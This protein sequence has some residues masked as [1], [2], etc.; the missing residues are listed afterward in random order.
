[1]KKRLYY[2]VLFTA[3][4]MLPDAASAQFA[5]KWM[6]VGSLHD[7]YSEIGCEIEEG[8]LKVQQYGLRWPAIYEF[9]DSKAA[10]AMWIGAKDFTDEN[11]NAF[12]HKVV[13]VGPRVSGD[14]EFFPI[15][16]RMTSQ[17]S[18]PEVAVDALQSFDLPVD[19][20]DV[21]EAL[22][23][24]RMIV[25]VTNSQ[26][27]VTMERKIFQFGQQYHDN[28]IVYDYTFTNTGNTDADDDIELP[29]QTLEGVYFFFHY[30]WS[31]ARQT[32]YVIGNATGWGINSMLDTRGDGVKEDPSDEQFRAQ[33]T[34]HGH[35]P[36]FT[37][38]DNLGAPIWAPDGPGFVADADTIGRLGSPQFVG[39]VTLHA[40]K[41]AAEQVDDPSQ[42]ATT[43]WESSD[44][45]LTSGNS[46]FD[47]VKMTREYE[48]M[49]A[50]HKSPRHVDVVEPSGNFA[51]PT[52]DPALGTPGGFSN[53]N[54]YGPYTLEP[55]QSIRIVLAEAVSGISREVATDIGV[56]YKNGEITAREKNEWVLSGQDSLFQTF[57]R[58]IANFESDW[59]I[60]RPPKPPQFFNIDGKGDR[61]SLSWETYDDNDSNLAGFRIY[62][63]RSEVDS[64]YTLIHEAGPAERSFEDRTP[65]RGVDYY[66]YI[67]SVGKAEDN[68]GAGMTPGGAL[69]SSRYYTQS[70]DPVNLKRPAVNDM[71]SIRVV[72]NPFVISA[73]NEV[74][75]SGNQRDELKFFN[76]PG[77]C[78]IKIFT[79]S[80]EL[81]E[82]IEHD[83]GT[84]DETWSSLT[85]SQQVIVSGVY[86]AVITNNETGEKHV[87]KFVI[88]R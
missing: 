86:I 65:I 21:D 84:G 75:F 63:A 51:E 44:H 73:S 18:P 16:F 46:A 37:A 36:P 61:I 14:G 42:P 11:G 62:R 35:Y 33:I 64:A 56:R 24:D 74:K 31:V 48:W 82:T 41:S 32:R 83:D 9:Q 68:T 30:R 78:T 6:A 45:D 85:S 81:V 60:P 66:Y 70:Y 8:L 55:G 52:G 13:H 34:Y 38:Y 25:N 7:W 57:R 71:D 53:M 43:I 22:V 3:F 40:D 47:Q 1:M 59:N 39:V 15:E 76:I 80:G 20:D 26:L 5:S 27:G 10:K 50:G 77:N 49:E 58:A 12:P 72:P 4:S 17:F 28:Y 88:V 54:G 29:N 69:L 87:E 19:N 79:E 2:C 67:V 23:P